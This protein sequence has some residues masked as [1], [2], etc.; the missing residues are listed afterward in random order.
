MLSVVRGLKLKEPPGAFTATPSDSTFVYLLSPPR[1][2][3]DVIAPY[4]PLCTRVA[5]G[6]SRNA[7]AT[8]VIPRAR[9]SSPDRIVTACDSVAAGRGTLD[10]ETTTVPSVV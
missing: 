2:K 1:R 10:A 9:R 3:S 7:S 4:E 5:P 6:T 8:L